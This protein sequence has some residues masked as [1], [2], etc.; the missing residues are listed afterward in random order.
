M[1]L[2]APSSAGAGAR[3]LALFRRTRAST[4][5]AGPSG[6]MKKREPLKKTTRKAPPTGRLPS[7]SRRTSGEPLPPTSN[8]EPGK[9]N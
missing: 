7:D 9:K 8:S 3:R 6:R 2:A 4:T 5:A 1:I